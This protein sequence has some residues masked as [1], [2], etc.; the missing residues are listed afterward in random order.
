M[1]ESFLKNKLGGIINTQGIK[2][3]RQNAITKI[4]ED[5]IYKR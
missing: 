4:L 1:L 5:V 3:D 2:K